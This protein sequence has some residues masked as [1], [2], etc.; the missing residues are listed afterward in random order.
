MFTVGEFAR[1]AQVSKRLLRYYD[2]IDLFKP[3]EVDSKSGF[4]LYSAEQMNQLNRILALKELGL[5]LDQIRRTLTAHVTTDEIQGMLLLK[6]AEIEQQMQAE[7]RKVRQIESRLQMIRDDESGKPLNVVMKKV[8]KQP[9]LST[10]RILPTFEDALELYRVID[11]QNRFGLGYCIC[12]TDTKVDYDL[13]MEFGCLLGNEIEKSLT[14]HNGIELQY[15]ELPAADRMATTVVTGALETLHMGYMQ[16]AKWAE[17][18]QY[19]P[20]GIPREITL[21]SPQQ[22][23]G[24][25]MITEIQL[26]VIPVKS[27]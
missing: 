24:S 3:M 8:A 1:L 21:Q 16:I 19:R 25:D 22:A 17:I 14:L 11:A 10:R 26:P 23:D 5:S 15:Q 12:Y 13:D 9:V 18:N 27:S 2:E 6:K 7:L 20:D 4:R